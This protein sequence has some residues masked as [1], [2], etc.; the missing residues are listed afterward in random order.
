MGIVVRPWRKSDLESIRDITWQSWISAYTSFIPESD[1]RTHLDTTYAE[2]S[3]LSMFDDPLMQGFVA[4]ANGTIAGYARKK[5]ID[6]KVM[7]ITEVVLEAM[8]S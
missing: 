4:E 8:G 5:E 6:L 1:L 2:A 7:D 3:L